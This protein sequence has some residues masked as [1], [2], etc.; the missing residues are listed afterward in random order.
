MSTV[1]DVLKAKGNITVHQIGPEAS[2]LDAMR[3]MAEHGIGALLVTQG[4]HILGIVTE[5]DYARKVLLHGRSSEHTPVREIMT[6]DV[7]YV[8]PEQETTACMALMTQR[9]MRHLPVMEGKR[10]VGLI[11]IGDLVKNII[12]EQQ[13]IISQL[14][15]Y[16]AG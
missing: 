6:P 13:F 1:A 8:G 14:E 2:V 10:L 7:L 16:I 15:R 12:D 5:R 4:E 3:R 9:R 11:S